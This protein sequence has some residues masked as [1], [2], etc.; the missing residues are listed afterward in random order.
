VALV[1]AGA[2]LLA[3]LPVHIGAQAQTKQG[4]QSLSSLIGLLLEA[5][6]LAKDEIVRSELNNVREAANRANK[7]NSRSAA[8]V[9]DMQQARTVLRHIVDDPRGE[10]AEFQEKI[11]S[12]LKLVD[13]FIIVDQPP[14]ELPS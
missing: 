7:G 6:S 1:L 13:D 3:S 9:N 10:S 4:E 11:A 2:L 12:S 8:T 14:V 5:D